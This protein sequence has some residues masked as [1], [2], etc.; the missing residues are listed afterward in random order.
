M[1]VTVTGG[2]LSQEEIDAYKDRA[3]KKFRTR[4]WKSWKYIWTATMPI[5]ITRSKRDRS[6]AFAG[7]QVTW[8]EQRTAGTTPSRRR[9]R[10][11]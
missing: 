7:S 4:L 11:G 1:K 6:S 8:L 2:E 9:K 3:N 5:C 10:T